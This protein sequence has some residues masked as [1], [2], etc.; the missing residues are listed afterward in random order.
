MK[1][2]NKQK[3][4]KNQQANEYNNVISWEC[5]DVVQTYTAIKFCL[6]KE[7]KDALNYQIKKEEKNIWATLTL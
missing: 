7:T 5:K 4:E 1:N 2:E 6:F 3:E